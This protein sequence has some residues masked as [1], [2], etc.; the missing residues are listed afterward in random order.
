MTTDEK[1]GSSRNV[2]SQEWSP[3]EFHQHRSNL[4]L[5][6]LFVSSFQVLDCSSEWMTVIQ[7]I[8][9]I[10]SRIFKQLFVHVY[11]DEYINLQQLPWINYWT[12]E[13]LV[14][15]YLHVSQ[16]CKRYT[17]RSEALSLLKESWAFAWLIK[18]K[19][20]FTHCQHKLT[21]MSLTAFHFL[22][23]SYASK[24][25][26]KKVLPRKDVRVYDEQVVW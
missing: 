17:S 6:T 13:H 7:I 16:S 2:F 26:Y 23:H 3:G 25:G 11:R 18:W 8:Y 10:C 24:P 19:E 1:A 12:N 9:R 4:S 14:H 15:P 20:M 5:H 21:A 22:S